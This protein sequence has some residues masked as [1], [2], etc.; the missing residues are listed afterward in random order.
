MKDAMS[1]MTGGSSSKKSST[2]NTYASSQPIRQQQP[3][4]GSSVVAV[5]D[6]SHQQQSYMTP[7][8]AMK[9]YMHKLTAFE[10]HEVFSFPHIYFAGQNARK[11]QGVVGGASNNGYDDEQ[12]SYIPVAHDHIAYRYEILKVIGKGSFGQVRENN[13]IVAS[14]RM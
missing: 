7:D 10:H 1:Q 5:G 11:R 6:S 13:R 4:N 2:T 9:Q 3:N 12:C 8:Q 14:C